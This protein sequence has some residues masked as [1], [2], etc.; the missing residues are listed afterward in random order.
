MRFSARSGDVKDG[1]GIKTDR[2]DKEYGSVRVRGSYGT[3][4]GAV[5]V[6]TYSGT[7]KLSPR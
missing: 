1:L 5:R 4:D 6:E 7:L 2:S 3:G